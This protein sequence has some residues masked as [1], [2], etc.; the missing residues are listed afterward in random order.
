MVATAQTRTQSRF[1]AAP[2]AAKA[3]FFTEP[4]AQRKRDGGEST[5]L[6]QPVNLLN[7]GRPTPRVAPRKSQRNLRGKRRDP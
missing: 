4:G 5:D 7:P 3:R 2:S 6:A 1:P